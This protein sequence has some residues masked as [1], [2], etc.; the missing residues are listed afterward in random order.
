MEAPGWRTEKLKKITLQSIKR[1]SPGVKGDTLIYGGVQWS[2][3]RK[4]MRVS[5]PVL[6]TR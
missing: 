4:V 3:S 2:C 5:L 1:I 6:L